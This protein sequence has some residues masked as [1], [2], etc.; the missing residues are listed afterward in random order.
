MWSIN[1][2]YHGEWPSTRHDESD[3]DVQARPL[4]TSK[5]GPGGTAKPASS[6]KFRKDKAGKPL[7]VRALLQQCRGDWMWYNE[8]FSFPSWASNEICWLC[9]ATRAGDRRFQNF[10]AEGCLAERKTVGGCFFCKAAPKWSFAFPSVRG[11]W[12]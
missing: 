11:H 9:S 2:L 8:L 6:D 5:S 1:N 4:G 7:G 3:F 10:F 12:V